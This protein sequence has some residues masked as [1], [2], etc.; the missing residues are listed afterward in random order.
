MF[1]K[2]C[3]FIIEN[4]DKFC[5][6]CGTKNFES[7]N[8]VNLKCNNCS[9]VMV[10]DKDKQILTCAY[11]G[12]T[13]LM[14][15]SDNVTVEKIRSDAYK[16]I[17]FKKLEF[18]Q[19]FEKER[20]QKKKQEAFSNSGFG[21]FTIVV[22]SISGFATLLSF[23]NVHILNGIIALV[24]TL[25]LITSVLIRKDVI[26]T[27]KKYLASIFAVV[28]LLLIIPFVVTIRVK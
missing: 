11:C 17:E 9:G 8:T 23:L 19:K 27:N 21:V 12:S 14:L 16:E 4:D 7:A 10:V 28:G 15:D 1:C 25:I 6:N 5:K 3:G 24:Q 13:E 18:Q 2:N 20:E 22:A 26:P